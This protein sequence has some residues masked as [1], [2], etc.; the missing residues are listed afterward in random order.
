MKADKLLME[1]EELLSAKG[2]KF[3]RERGNFRNGSCLLEGERLIML[4]RMLPPESQIAS[5]CALFKE[6]DFEDQF[7]KP[8]VRKELELYWQRQ[9]R[10]KNPD[11]WDQP[12]DGASV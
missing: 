3:R 1:L 8:S 10:M 2:Y 6:G 9:Q 5:L 12:D 7:I 4:N 11:L